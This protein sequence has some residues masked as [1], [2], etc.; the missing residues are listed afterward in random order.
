MSTPAS[1]RLSPLACSCTTVRTLLTS[2]RLSDLILFA[3]L[4]V[5]AHGSSSW[6]TFGDPCAG[7]QKWLAVVMQCHLAT[8]IMDRPIFNLGTAD[9]V[10]QCPNPESRIAQV[11]IATA[12][13]PS[14]QFAEDSD[15]SCSQSP[16]LMPDL[17]KQNAFMPKWVTVC[18]PEADGAR[19]ACFGID[20]VQEEAGH[21][22][23][24]TTPVMLRIARSKEAHWSYV[25]AQQ[26]LCWYREPQLIK[27]ENEE[28]VD[29]DG[30]WDA[31][32]GAATKVKG[33]AKKVYN[34]A[35]DGF[36]KMKDRFTKK[37]KDQYTTPTL[38]CLRYD[39]KTHALEMV[40]PSLSGMFYQD[41][42]DF[43][44]SVK[45]AQRESPSSG[46]RKVARC[47]PGYRI[48]GAS[49]STKDGILTQSYPKSNG[50]WACESGPRKATEEVLLQQEGI[51]DKIKAAANKFKDKFKD[52]V[53]EKTTRTS[54]TLT[55]AKVNR[56][57]T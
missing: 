32:K 33:A 11:L 14:P 30:I 19:D 15:M 49:C 38:N 57:C 18:S 53:F 56:A 27:S 4:H 3:C 8:P 51:F 37:K 39:T 52:G 5:S 36:N 43:R 34:K 28:L 31:V 23:L 47:S 46:S 22:E 9:P 40:R 2:Q 24:Q 44:W 7:T 25:P 54:M 12:G 13:N 17:S 16:L 1:M 41:N 10:I 45:S 42:Q 6:Q 21:K 26:Q 48:L 29:A 50:E 35:K 20:V 55:C